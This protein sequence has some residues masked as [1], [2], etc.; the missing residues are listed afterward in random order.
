MRKGLAKGLHE[1]ALGLFGPHD[2]VG[3]DPEMGQ[4]R[5][6]LDRRHLEPQGFVQPVDQNW[7]A[8]HQ[9]TALHA[10]T[11]QIAKQIGGRPDRGAV[12]RQIF[13][14]CHQIKIGAV[15][16]DHGACQ[17]F[18]PDQLRGVFGKAA[19]GCQL[20]FDRG[21]RHAFARLRLTARHFVVKR[22]PRQPVPQFGV[23]PD[24][25]IVGRCDPLP[26]L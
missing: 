9:W 12:G 8:A 23:K 25:R 24:A 22:Q 15:R 5:V 4:C 17:I 7:G 6:A 26:P 18:L 1:I 21:R 19:Q 3:V 13:R 10:G 20:G 14:P 11:V 2:R 16:P